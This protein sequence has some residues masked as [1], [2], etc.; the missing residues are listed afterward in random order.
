MTSQPRLANL[1][2]AL[3]QVSDLGMGLE[4]EA[5]LRVCLFATSLGRELDLDDKTLSDVYY[6]ALLQHSGCTAHAYETA[7]ALADDV[8]TNRVGFRTNFADPLEMVRSSPRACPTSRSPDG[9]SCR[10]GLLSTTS[11]TFT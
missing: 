10:H 11:R 7:L 6:T 1:L 9:S 3:S 4:P 2:S 8:T 5:A